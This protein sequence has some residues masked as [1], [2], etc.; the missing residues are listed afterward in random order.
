MWAFVV[1]KINVLLKTSL[2]VDVFV[3]GGSHLALVH[4]VNMFVE[5]GSQLALVHK[6]NMFC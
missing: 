4:K 6:V 2:M 1:L 5:G 3:E